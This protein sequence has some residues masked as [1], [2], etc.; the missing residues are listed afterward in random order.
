MTEK[1][2][3]IRIRKELREALKKKKKYSRETYSEVI[4]RELK[5]A[6]KI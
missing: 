1:G 4:K 3:M 2:V 6:K 5:E